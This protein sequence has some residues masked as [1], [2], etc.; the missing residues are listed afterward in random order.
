MSNRSSQVQAKICLDRNHN[1]FIQ[2]LRDQLHLQLLKSKT[3]LTQIEILLQI[4]CPPA[5]ILQ[6]IRLFAKILQDKDQMNM[7]LPLMAIYHQHSKIWEEKV[8]RRRKQNIKQNNWLMSLKN[9]RQL[10]QKLDL[11]YL[12]AD[13]RHRQDLR[14]EDSKISKNINSNQWPARDKIM[15]YESITYFTRE[16]YI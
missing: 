1:L 10:L 15:T 5:K 12:R 7:F 4:I 16:L 9:L 3:V 14:T 8:L 2:K 13:G 11:F 6:I